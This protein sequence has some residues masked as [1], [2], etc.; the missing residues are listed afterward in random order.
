[1][2]KAKWIVFGNAHFLFLR[3]FWFHNTLSAILHKR[4]AIFEFWFIKTV[5]ILRIIPLEIGFVR[6]LQT[7]FV[8]MQVLIVSKFP[9][10]III[11]KKQM[12][13]YLIKCFMQIL[14]FSVIFPTDFFYTF[15]QEYF[16]FINKKTCFS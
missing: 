14:W 8:Y 12:F 16:Y 15:F 10:K 11:N 3:T 5:L 2:E 13:D 6:L 7:I 4:K 9:K 1:M